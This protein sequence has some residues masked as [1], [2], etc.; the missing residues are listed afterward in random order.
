M[1]SSAPQ[2]PAA[3]IEAVARSRY[4]RQRLGT[5]PWEMVIPSGQ[6]ALRE[7]ACA[8][9]LAAYPHLLAAF[10]KPVEEE[11]DLARR[12]AEE[13]EDRFESCENC[14]AWKRSGCFLDTT[15]EGHDG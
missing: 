9:L 7:A 14:E 13:A 6:E 4:E 5:Q 11:L 10:R 3:A 8:D 1:P 12:H 2:I 15:K